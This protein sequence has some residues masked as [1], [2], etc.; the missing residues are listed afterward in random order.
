MKINTTNKYSFWVFACL[1]YWQT[2][3]LEYRLPKDRDI[4]R[5]EGEVAKYN[6]IQVQ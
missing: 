6:G 1:F 2:A 3:W 4:A 5:D